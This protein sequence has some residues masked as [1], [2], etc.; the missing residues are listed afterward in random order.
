MMMKKG[1]IIGTIIASALV[2]YWTRMRVEERFCRIDA[3]RWCAEC[4]YNL[5]PEDMVLPSKTR[6]CVERFGI[7]SIP[8]N[9]TPT[10]SMLRS[11]CERLI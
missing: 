4:Y 9:E 11:E 3:F 5:W 6:V 1:I 2:A 10:C 7:L 8:F